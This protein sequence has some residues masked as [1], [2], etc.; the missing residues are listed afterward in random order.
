MYCWPSGFPGW[1][2]TR[3]LAPSIPTQYCR[4]ACGVTTFSGLSIVSIHTIG[5]PSSLACAA[6]FSQKG[7]GSR[8][9]HSSAISTSQS[10]SVLPG[11]TTTCCRPHRWPV[12]SL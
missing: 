6:N 3:T 7:A 12:S 11:P 5:R 8:T 4:S 10:S 9:W 2:S 1:A